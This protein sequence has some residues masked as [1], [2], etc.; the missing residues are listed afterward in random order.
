MWIVCAP[1]AGALCSDGCA[2]RQPV[3]DRPIATETTPDG[4]FVSPAPAQ[5]GVIVPGDPASG[6]AGIGS[7]SG[8]LDTTTGTSGSRVKPGSAND[9]P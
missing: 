2:G 9:G 7:G 5:K 4:G 6:T 3:T 1:L 8:R